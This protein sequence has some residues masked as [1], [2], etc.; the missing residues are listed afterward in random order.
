M[1]V[2]RVVVEITYFFRFSR[3]PERFRASRCVYWLRNSLK[4]QKNDL[5]KFFNMCVYVCICVVDVVLQ[6]SKGM[7]SYYRHSIYMSHTSYV[8]YHASTTVSP[9]CGSVKTCVFIKNS[10]SS[11]VCDRMIVIKY[12]VYMYKKLYNMTIS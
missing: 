6:P 3:Q 9:T 12:I 2:S 7:T 11:S 4:K 10:R 1:S 8:H 5:E